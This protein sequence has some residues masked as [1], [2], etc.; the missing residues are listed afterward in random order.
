MFNLP[1]KN[2]LELAEYVQSPQIKQILELPEPLLQKFLTK[3]V[4][5]LERKKVPRRVALAYQLTAPFLLENRSILTF[6]AVPANSS[7][8]P[9]LPDVATPDEA[10]QLAQQEYQLLPQEVK[11]LRP[12]LVSLVNEQS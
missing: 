7:L 2:R 10:L 12:L 1:H 9:A 4:S 3:Q 6:L 8:S 5:D 11:K